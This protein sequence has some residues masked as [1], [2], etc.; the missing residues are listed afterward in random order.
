M[1]RTAPAI[2]L[3]DLVR[4]GKAVRL[5]LL[6]IAV[7]SS[8]LIYVG[9]AWAF[10]EEPIHF[11][12]PYTGQTGEEWEEIST[13]HD[14]LTYVLAL[15]AGFSISDS[16]TLQIWDQLVDSE[17]IGPGDAISYTNCTG[18]AF[19][20]PPD[21]DDVCGW[22]P[23]S[24]LIWPM[25]GSV[26]DADHCV[27]S[28]FGPYSPFFH[29]PH[30]NNREV[31]ALHD[32]GWG[33]T[34]TL[35]AY[36]AYAWGG[37]G[38]FTVMQASC[39]YT[40][41]AAITTSIQAGSL[42][43]FATYIHSL[44]DYYSHRECIALMDSLGMPWATHTLTGYPACDYNPLNP[45]P[46]DVHGREFY[47][48]T[49]S[50]RTD[51]AIQH[52]Y[53]ELVA[54]SLQREGEYFPLGMDT[55]LTAIS[56]TPTLSETLSTFVHEWDFE[57]PYERRAWADQIAAAVLAQRSPLHRTYLPLVVALQQGWG[58]P[59]SGIT[60]TYTIFKKD[61]VYGTTPPT[62]TDMREDDGGKIYS[63]KEGY[64]IRA[65]TVYRA[66]DGQTLL[67]HQ[68]V[69]F[70]VHGGAWIDGYRDWYQFVAYP[71]TGEEGWVTVVVDYRLTSDQVFIADQNCSL[72][73]TCVPTEAT[74]AAWYPD[75][76]DD[77][78]AAFQWT[79]D[80]IAENGGDADKII[81]FGHSAG[82]HLASLLATST[83]TDHQAIPRSAIKGL[84]SMS[85]AYDLNSL[86]H[87]FWD[88]AVTQTFHG[89]FDS[90][91]LL[92]Q[93]SP[94]TYVV[95]DTTLPPFYLLYAEDDLLSLTEQSLVFKNRLET[96]GFDATI[97]YLAG[98]G[99]YTEMEA[100]AY[101]DEPPTQLIINWIEQ[102]LQE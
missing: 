34:D 9:L 20:P 83:Y 55:P 10:A 61:F 21:P 94:S 8:L 3:K 91:E 35:S 30:N 84:I 17:Q 74:K 90:V 56:G 60:T 18:G 70:F 27:T 52:M 102:V 69:V 45:Q 49:D 32:W 73:A 14:D 33:L 19:Y 57:H 96:L 22:K 59:V 46:D 98:Y 75:N 100:I 39:L 81:V 82:G 50:L 11:R 79:V 51:A 89:G 48:Y 13:I 85:G 53:R 26:K 24:H 5:W 12:D 63:D 88:S 65:L 31:G 101:F 78:A 1:K 93:A 97:S 43:A 37:P 86:N 67:D 76:I 66:Y 38:E 4:S 72:R 58:E 92:E 87:A 2:P 77:V 29:F 41:T 99:H 42:E 15:A 47:T 71:F 23:H 16:I 54:R 44:A 40:R 25:W 6:V 64:E 36:E 28:R 80:H 62:V 95:S 7:T 68:P